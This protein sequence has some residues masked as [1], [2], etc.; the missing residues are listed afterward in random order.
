MGLLRRRG[1]KYWVDFS[2]GVSEPRVALR[3]T[4]GYLIP[5]RWGF[6]GVDRLPHGV[7]AEAWRGNIGLHFFGW[8]FH[9]GA[10]A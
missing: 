7:I 8:G 10:L 5:P 1:G 2:G 3:S 6:G 4:L 9:L